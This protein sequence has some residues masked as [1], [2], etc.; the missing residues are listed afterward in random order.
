MLDM[1][2]FTEG[3]DFKHDRQ[4]NQIN[5]LHNKSKIGFIEADI[6][7]DRQGRK[8][9]GINATSNH[10][11]EAD[12]LAQTMFITAVSRR[13]RRNQNKQPSISIVT[14]NPNDTHLKQLYYNPYKAGTLPKGVIVVEFDISDSWQTQTDIEAMKTNPRPWVERYINNN[15]D[16]SDDD[17]S[18]FKYRYF[19]ASITKSI[20]TNAVRYIGYDVARSGQD[21]SV[22]CQWWGRT[23]IDIQIIKNKDEQ[24]ATDDQALELIKYMTQNAV[25]ARN[26]SIDGVGV[27][28][29]VI[30]HMKS[31]GIIVQEFISGARPTTDRYNNLRSQVIY[32]FA[33]GLERGDIKIYD[34]C[35]FRNELISEAML[36][37]HKIDDK[38]LAVESKDKIKERTGGMSPDIFDCVV[39]G[40][41][42]QLKIDPKND[43]RRIVF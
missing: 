4:A 27:G 37:S 32:E 6:S 38:K 13:G 43:T 5:F 41:F 34:G 28:V 18:L 20:D 12:E 7:K 29:G 19:D 36:H 3:E 39:Y 25:I 30:D 24:M 9:K 26:V 31:K 17:Q 10:I 42:P 8:I 11:D 33:Q 23:L 35:P 40:L 21:R 22:V 2:N 1:M 16:Y 15:W 14:M